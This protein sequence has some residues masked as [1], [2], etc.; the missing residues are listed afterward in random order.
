MNRIG[1]DAIIRLL[2]SLVF[3][4]VAA[5]MLWWGV[6]TV[7]NASIS[8]DWPAVPGTIT[9]SQ[10]RISTDEDG[11]TYFADVTYKYVVNDRWY[12]AATVHFGEY[13]SGSRSRADK[14]VARYPPGSQ[15]TVYYNPDKSGTA[16][17]EPGVS[18]S[19]YLGIFMSLAFFIVPVAMLLSFII[20]KRR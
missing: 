4:L 12:T 6:D 16:V 14:I 20:Q 9:A 17:L 7:R 1:C 13:G 10:V 19:S 2:F 11:T 8:K 3:L 15:V 5:G 18:W